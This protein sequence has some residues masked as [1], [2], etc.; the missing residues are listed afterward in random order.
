MNATI[1]DHKTVAQVWA[2]EPEVLT[3]PEFLSR[4]VAQILASEMAEP[5]YSETIES[6]E[7]RYWTLAMKD[8]ANLVGEKVSPRMV[9][10]VVGRMGLRTTRRANG[11][12][13]FWNQAQLSLIRAALEV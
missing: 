4:K 5:R 6:S 3:V 10:S 13:L 9:G 12:R 11:Y 2:A 8:L 1:L 7:K